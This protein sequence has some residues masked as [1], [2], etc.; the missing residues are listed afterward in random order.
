MDAEPPSRHVQDG[1]LAAKRAVALWGPGMLIT[2]VCFGAGETVEL[3]IV[4]KDAAGVCKSLGGDIFT[5]S[6]QRAGDTQPA[7]AGTPPHI[8]AVS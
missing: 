2:C 5:I 7:T 8:S 6:W 1:M 4:A 3:T